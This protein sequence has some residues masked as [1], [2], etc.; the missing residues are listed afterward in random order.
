M[1]DSEIIRRLM[2]DMQG[3][4]EEQARLASMVPQYQILNYNQPA[5]LTANVN[6]YNPGDYDFLRLSSDASPRNISGISGGVKGRV[7]FLLVGGS[8]TIALLHLSGLSIAANQIAT[9]GGTT[10]TMNP[11][12]S[13]GVNSVVMLLYDGSFW[14]VLFK[15]AP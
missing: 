15:S 11:H 5:Q 7:L 9:L 3:L 8:F 12:T 6:N 2:K 1:S 4:K 10:T 14:R 13:S